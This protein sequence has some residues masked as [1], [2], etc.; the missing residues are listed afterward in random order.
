MASWAD[1]VG[2]VNSTPSGG[3]IISNN[4]VTDAT[5]IR[6]ISVKKRSLI[7]SATACGSLKTRSAQ[8]DCGILF[9]LGYHLKP[10]KSVYDLHCS[11]PLFA[12]SICFP[13]RAS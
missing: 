1:F 2:K 8:F 6:L 3:V 11:F 4:C 10:S 12:N 5:I 7:F 13:C 9:C